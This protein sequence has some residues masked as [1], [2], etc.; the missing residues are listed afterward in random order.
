MQ[1]TPLAITIKDLYKQYPDALTPALAGLTLN[2][3]ENSFTGL[4]G[5]NGAGKTTCISILC[6]LVI[7]ESG[8][9]TV[10]GLDCKKDKVAIRGVT[11]VVPQEIALFSN[12][13]GFENLKYIGRLYGLTDKEIKQRSGE[14]M[15]RFGLEKHAHKRV[16]RYSGGMQRRA[17]I[18]ASLMHRPKLLI[19]DEP[20]AGVDV[21]S[22]ALILE[23]LNEY[24]QNGNTILYTSHSLEEAQKMC[25][26]VIIMDEG[27]FVT[28]GKPK[29]LIKDTPDCKTLEDVFLHHTGHTLRD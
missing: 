5:P 16:S 8:Q 2:V 17:N 7:P 9:A 12:L 25:D 27:K 23:Y 13:T 24:R 20:T 22:R 1:A 3:R 14:L 10:Y 18:I 26:E 21:Q 15:E 29:Q 4:L 19:L 11:G 6:G 28:T